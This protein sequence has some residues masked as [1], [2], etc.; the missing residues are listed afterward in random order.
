MQPSRS[1]SGKLHEEVPVLGLVRLAQ[2]HCGAMLMALRPTCVL[3]L[4]GQTSTHRLQPVQSSGAT[5]RV[6]LHALE[7]PSNLAVACT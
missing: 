2:R 4:A 7:I 1:R 6:Y 3:S 5:W